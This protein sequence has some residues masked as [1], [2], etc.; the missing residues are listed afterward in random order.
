MAFGVRPGR[1]RAL[2]SF[3]I[4]LIT[5]LVTIGGVAWADATTTLAVLTQPLT[6]EM[7]V[8]AD[9]LPG[10]RS[11]PT[12]ITSPEAIVINLDDNKVLWEKNAHTT[13]PM[14]STTK[15][16]TA[17]IVLENM[18]MSTQVT[19]SP[20][21]ASKP[22]LEVWAKAGDVFTV[23]QL[24]YSLMVP[25]HNQAAVALAEAYPGGQEAFVAKMNAKAKELGL[26]GTHYVN[27][28][29]L[30]TTDQHSTAADLAALARYGMTDETIGATFRKLVSTREYSL[31]VPGSQSGALVLQTSNELLASYDWV[32]GVKTGETPLAKSCLVAA[33]T[34]DG[35]TIV[36]VVLGQPDHASSFT[37]SEELLEYGFS[38]YPYALILDKGAA[39]AEGKVSDE[40]KPLEIVAKEKVGK[41]L[42]KGQSLTAK[43]VIDHG[44]V[45]PVKAGEVVGRVELTVDGS[46]AGSVDLVTS[47]E[48][49]RPTLGTKI[50]RFF[51]GLF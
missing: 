32:I 21:A 34:R 43:V 36:S 41:G 40:E 12:D 17:V 30:D 51:A 39:I 19:I 13:V 5:V 11:E 24:L 37:E 38:Q 33:G 6:S 23:E 14:A 35:V 49:E 26:T 45:L 29:G 22:E 8:S 10:F 28:S 4:A 27:P 47:R 15:M 50:V 3:G 7:T 31:E 25:S 44:V 48:V 46:S 18:D 20:N 42:A 9:Q 1:L 16:M 2:L